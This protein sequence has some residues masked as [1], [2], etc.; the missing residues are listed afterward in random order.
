MKKLF[1]V[2]IYNPKNGEVITDFC[3]ISHSKDYLHQKYKKYTLGFP[4]YKVDINKI[5]KKAGEQITIDFE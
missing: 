1:N 2:L 4:K 3:E 5:T